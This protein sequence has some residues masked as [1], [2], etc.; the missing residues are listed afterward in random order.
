MFS[1]K[2]AKLNQYFENLEK[3]VRKEL[4]AEKWAPISTLYTRALILRKNEV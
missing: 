4:H 1:L 2:E 3:K